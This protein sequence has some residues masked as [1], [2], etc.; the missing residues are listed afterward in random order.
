MNV[1]KQIIKDG[2][3]G[4]QTIKQIVRS[5]ERGPQGE[6]GEPGEA[7]T[8]EAGAAYVVESGTPA[9]VVNTG[10][11]SN[12]VFDFYIP[13][14]DK[15]EPGKDGEDGAIRYKAGPGIKI[16]LDHVIEA[17]GEAV[18]T[19]GDIEGDI[20]NQ[21][22]LN[23]YLEK[24]DTAIQPS[25]INYTL[26]SD[27]NLGSNNSTS[28]VELDAA[29]VNIATGD[30]SSKQVPLP[31]ASSQQAGVI[32]SATFDAITNNTTNINAL[33][34]GSVAVTGL[35][36]NPTQAELTAAWTSETGLSTLINRAQVLDVTNELVWTYYTNTSTWYSA[37]AGGQLTVSTFT[38]TSEGLIKGS[39]GTGQVFAENDGTGSVNGWDTLVA[40]VNSNT[41]NKLATNNLSA[42]NGI[43]KTTSGSGASTT[44]A[45]SLTDVGVTTAKI[46]N[47]AV[48]SAK[49][50]SSSV[51]EGKIASSAVTTVKIAS[52][53]VTGPK[54]S[55][56]TLGFTHK[57]P[58]RVDF[59]SSSTA[60]TR[61]YPSGWDLS[62]T[63]VS[64]GLYE[65][66]YMTDYL[67]NNTGSSD[68]DFGIE[69]VSGGTSKG[70]APSISSGGNGSIARSSKL[71]VEASSTTVKVKGY[72]SV[73]A[74]SQSISLYGGVA[75]ARR[76]A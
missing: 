26:V 63:A 11:S 14:G 34:N 24:V 20:T 1:I 49:L 37:P 58:P 54:I 9:A 23:A 19:W 76:V 6:Q 12:A 51:T 17:T 75:T 28:I 64:G 72:V 2:E 65:V 45:L 35:S 62:F 73:G 68:L 56:S 5:N 46:A 42:S 66:D 61:A 74:A 33:L 7:A 31:V 16:T 29:K 39:T 44:V 53:A 59:T 22:D 32:N 55:W 40:S 38:N 3:Y 50:A 13:K 52:G 69:I 18:T 36:S 15:G 47:S 25:D 67:K 48:T 10:T 71:L 30:T 70:F 8:I 27:I 4:T 43:T 21:A 57:E 60:Y 41:N